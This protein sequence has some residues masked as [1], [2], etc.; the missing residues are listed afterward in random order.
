[1]RYILGNSAIMCFL[2]YDDLPEAIP[3]A[4]KPLERLFRRKPEM[5]EKNTFLLDDN[6]KY[7][8]RV[9]LAA[10]IHIVPYHPKMTKEGLLEDD[11]RLLQVMDWLMRPEVFYANDIRPLDKSRETI[12]GEQSDREDNYSFIV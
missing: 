12:F 11:D 4:E 6:K 5:N 8:E 1:M 7:F 2:K 3:S 9:N 10:A